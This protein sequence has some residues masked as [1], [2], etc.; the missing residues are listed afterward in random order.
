MKLD[1]IAKG[2]YGVAYFE[3]SSI[4]TTTIGNT[5]Y[6]NYT[7][8][9]ENFNLANTK[10]LLSKLGDE[11]KVI[12]MLNNNGNPTAMRAVTIKGL[13]A[14]WAY[15]AS[16]EGHTR[17]IKKIAK[18]T[19]SAPVEDEAQA[20]KSNHETNT[21]ED[22]TSIKPA[23]EESSVEESSV[24]QPTEDQSALSPKYESESKVVEEVYNQAGVYTY[25]A[26]GNPLTKEEAEHHNRVLDE[27][28]ESVT[29]TPTDDG[30]IAEDSSA[31]IPIIEEE[32]NEAESRVQRSQGIEEANEQNTKED[33]LII[34]QIQNISEEESP[35]TVEEI[36][37]VE[38]IN[39]E[40]EPIIFEA[41]DLAEEPAENAVPNLNSEDEV[42]QWIA[43]MDTAIVEGSQ[44]QLVM[45]Q[46][47]R[48][49]L[50]MVFANNEW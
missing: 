17:R 4:R 20:I 13:Q 32:A 21:I 41:D 9:L 7:D 42:F 15:A 34:P 5:V 33:P 19:P 6:Y 18:D 47:V 28:E 40:E 11:C 29:I 45:K 37:Q 25:D 36:P 39:K 26:F 22:E 46:S 38:D 24:D 30:F 14:I 49:K 12:K 1:V 16:G 3:N 44:V 31:Q 50:W 27:I 23:V 43:L 35:S 2:E 48:T 8:L 10:A